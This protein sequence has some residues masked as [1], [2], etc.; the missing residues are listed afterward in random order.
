MIM[1]HQRQPFNFFVTIIIP[2]V[3]HKNNN[4]LNN[5]HINEITM[6][7]IYILFT[8]NIVC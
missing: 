8:Y 3:W 4:Y 1:L 6:M 2:Y 7:N 5:R